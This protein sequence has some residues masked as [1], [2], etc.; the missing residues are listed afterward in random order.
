MESPSA[1]DSEFPDLVK[2]LCLQVFEIERYEIR[3]VFYGFF[4]FYSFT[5]GNF[6][7]FFEE[8]SSLER[9]NYC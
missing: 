3:K 2:E 1:L 6:F 7:F 8:T 4:F 5:Q 9:D